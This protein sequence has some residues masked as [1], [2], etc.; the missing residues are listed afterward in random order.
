MAS[1]LG[2]K[3]PRT[4]L[5]VPSRR[6]CRGNDPSSLLNCYNIIFQLG[7]FKTSSLFQTCCSVAQ[8]QRIVLLCV[9]LKSRGIP[10]YPRFG[11]LEH[12]AF[13]HFLFSGLFLLSWLYFSIF[14]SVPRAAQWNWDGSNNCYFLHRSVVPASGP[15]GRREEGG[16]DWRK[17]NM[18]RPYFSHVFRA[19]QLGDDERRGE[20]EKKKKNGQNKQDGRKIV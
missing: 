16:R 12:F 15:E 4:P 19:N 1:K 8:P 11:L 9:S 17:A 6:Y 20:E 14:F 2:Q 10:A 7:T 5:V 3:R 18:H 13:R